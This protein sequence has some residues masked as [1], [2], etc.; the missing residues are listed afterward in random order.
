MPNPLTIIRG[1]SR[2]Q[3]Y[4]HMNIMDP[5][6]ASRRLTTIFKAALDIPV[7]YSLLR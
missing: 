4:P 7:T 3:A 2:E 6:L 5:Y 1:E